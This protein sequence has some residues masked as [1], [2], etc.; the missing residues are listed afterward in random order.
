MYRQKAAE[1]VVLSHGGSL[2]RLAGFTSQADLVRFILM[3]IK[4]P[5]LYSAHR[6]PHK[7]WLLGNP[8]F[9][10]Y[11]DVEAIVNLIHYNDAAKAV[12]AA[13]ER[14]ISAIRLYSTH[15]CIDCN[16]L[17]QGKRSKCI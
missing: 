7:Y 1:D 9:R 16:H 4:C 2:I 10:S 5:G 8:P 15:L 17:L 13:L 12:V 3:L 14:G 11:K 6:G